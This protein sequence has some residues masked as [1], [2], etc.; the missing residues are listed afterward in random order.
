MVV[1]SSKNPNNFCV[2]PNGCIGLIN[3][4][5]IIES[6]YYVSGYK[7]DFCENLYTVPFES[8]VLQI[9]YY[10]IS[11]TKFNRVVPTKKCIG[12]QKPGSSQ[13]VIFPYIN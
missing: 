3:K 9:G 6:K 12:Y 5:E 7:L 13:I 10:S 11:H 1:Y 4:A 2:L 8:R